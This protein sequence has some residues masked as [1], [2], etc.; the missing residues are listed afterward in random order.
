M[1]HRLVYYVPGPINKT[2]KSL[3]VHLH[4]T[5]IVDELVGVR[6]LDGIATTDL[7]RQREDAKETKLLIFPIMD[8]ESA[9]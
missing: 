1:L 4:E 5:T 7:N 8:L 9:T 6:N 3:Q 2:S